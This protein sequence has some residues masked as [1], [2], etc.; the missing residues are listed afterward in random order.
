MLLLAIR[1]FDGADPCIHDCPWIA[2]EGRLANPSPPHL[3]PD[4]LFPVRHRDALEGGRRICIQGHPDLIELCIREQCHVLT[5]PRIPMLQN[6][7]SGHFLAHFLLLILNNTIFIQNCQ[8]FFCK[9]SDRYVSEEGVYWKKK[10]H[11]IH[12]QKKGPSVRSLLFSL[13]FGDPF[14]EARSSG[15]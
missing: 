7:L 5:A 4:N 6:S 13:L 10:Y 1:F 8:V 11:L 3:L 14:C 9:Y 12:T 15:S 2:P